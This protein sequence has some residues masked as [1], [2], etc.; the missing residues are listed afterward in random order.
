VPDPLLTALHPGPAASGAAVASALARSL[1]PPA[2]RDSAPEWLLPEQEP[3]FRRSLAA[4]RSHGGAVL[5]DPVG[6]GKTFVA[7]AVAAALNRG[8]TACLVPATLLGQWGRAATRVGISLSLCSH[9]QVSRGRLPPDTRG[10]VIIDESHHFRNPQTRRY[11]HLAPWLVGRR[12]LLLTATP[13]VN[14]LGDLAHQLLLAVRDDA[15]AM[16]GIVSIRKLLETGR[17][18]SALGQLVI[19]GQA[20]T[21]RP[22]RIYR[23]SRPTPAECATLRHLI[24]S[25]TRLRLSQSEPIAT[26]IRGVMLRAA[27]SSPA[28]LSAVLRRYR[29]LLLHARDASRAGRTLDRAE[30]RKFTGESGNQLIWWELLPVPESKSE[31][32]VNDLAPLEELIRTTAAATQAGDEKLYRLRGFLNDGMPTLVFT[33][34]RDTVHYLRD[35]LRDLRVA[36]CTGKRA[37]IGGGTLPRRSVLDWFREPVTSS[38]APRHLIVTDVAAEG[39]DLQRAARVIH[40]DLPWTPM[41]LEQR[42]GRSVRY[43]S[44][45]A[46]VHLVR[47]AAPP[48]LERLL[49]VEAT[50]DRKAK[51]PAAAGLGPDNRHLWRW[52]VSLAEQFGRPAPCAGV[53]G[54]ISSREGLLAGFTLS[55]A[56]YADRD[57][58]TILW[59]EPNG[60]WTEAPETVAGWLAVAAVQKEIFAVEKDRLRHWLSLLA[61]PIRE[62]LARTRS[63]RW[64]TADPAPAARR[65]TARLQHLI[66]EA[67]RRHQADRLAELERALAFVAGGH[68]AGEAMLVEQLAKASGPE[69]AGALRKFPQLRLTSGGI[70]VRL[71]GLVVFGG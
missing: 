29:T 53:A 38:L 24:E 20:V 61:L 28:A 68:T 8:S 34:S 32:E 4:L 16:D 48:M 12:A 10:L 71:N 26:L 46:Q 19:E 54:A 36:W 37:G 70:E 69:V 9:E 49:Q 44:Q 30:L 27:G 2:A 1:A 64:V 7:L 47:F 22:A 62:R 59:I 50:L 58:P 55:P 3:S 18:A 39:L 56:G 35:R 65:L 52:R 51:L 15:L 11:A 67:A 43:G 14:R 17:P 41:R 63:R 66:G 6:S 23:S 5:A 40:Y 45:N 31:I 25:L 33:A 60:S 42:E 21:R 13:I 57:C